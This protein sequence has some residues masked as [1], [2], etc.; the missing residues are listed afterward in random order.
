[1]SM[2]VPYIIAKASA[3]GYMAVLGLTFLPS[4]SLL[5]MGEEMIYTI[6]GTRTTASR[7]KER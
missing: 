6:E 1:M 4:L 2:L 3:S 7:T 5:M